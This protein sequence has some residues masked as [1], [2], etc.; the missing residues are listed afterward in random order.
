MTYQ[1][2][3]EQVVK[4]PTADRLTI[5]EVVSR[6]L[7]E[8][9]AAQSQSEPTVEQKLAAMNRLI[10]IAKTDIPAPTDQEL[11][12]DYTDYLTRKYS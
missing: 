5:L 8:E 10:G 4:L 2:I 7:R 12:D 6:S 1:E 11:K 9:F 3:I